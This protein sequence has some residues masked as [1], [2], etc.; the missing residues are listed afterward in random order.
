MPEATA[1]AD[2]ALALELKIDLSKQGRAR[3][4]RRLGKGMGTSATDK[5]EFGDPIR[6]TG[7]MSFAQTT[8]G[9]RATPE[10]AAQSLQTRTGAPSPVARSTRHRSPE[11][12]QL[13]RP[14]AA[15]FSDRMRSL[16]PSRGSGYRGS[17][18]PFAASRP[19]HGAR[20]R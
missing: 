8:M 7:S 4:L 1:V 3:F 9:A 18:L 11:T 6:D 5:R 13:G 17:G 10:R 15:A 19:A 2:H 12:T 20:T 16:A 14:G